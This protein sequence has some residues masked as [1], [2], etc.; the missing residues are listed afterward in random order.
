MPV[1]IIRWDQTHLS[2]YSA[3]QRGESGT[4]NVD[5][6]WTRVTPQPDSSQHG[7]RNQDIDCMIVTIHDRIAMGTL[8]GFVCRKTILFQNLLDYC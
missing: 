2:H 3:Q 1:V 8:V 6:H 4:S 7:P 5:T